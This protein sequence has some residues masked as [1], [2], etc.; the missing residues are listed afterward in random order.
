MDIKFFNVGQGDSILLEWQDDNL[1]KIGV[2]DCHKHKSGNPIKNYLNTKENF[3][4]EFII[5]SHPHRDH[6]SGI[7]ELLDFIESKDY[8]I[9]FFLHTVSV[10]PMYLNWAEI[11]E[12]DSI[13]LEL[14]FDKIIRFN[15]EKEII[16][17]I[18][19]GVENWSIDLNEKYAIKLLA[20]SDL[21]TRTFTSKINYYK[22]EN[23]NEC[24]AA[25]NLLS[26]V[27]KITNRQ[28][29]KVALLTSDAEIL[30]FE[31]LNKTNLIQTELDYFQV[32]HHGS[33]NNHLP[34]FWDSLKFK[35]N[36]K[37]IISAGKNKKYNH[38]DYEVVEYF[39]LRKICLESTNY[40]NGFKNYFDKL[41]QP[42]IK[43]ANSLD[44]ISEELEE[45]EVIEYL[46]Y[47]L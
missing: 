28:N 17:S 32:P 41:K 24:S 19:I 38:P 20:P 14:L 34:D 29:S 1:T 36:T 30:T 35:G 46:E 9:N 43:I 5:L 4:L 27:I 13:K 8:K 11:N 22:E 45:N 12:D 39:D 2:I 7:E 16:K 15:S 47:S 31:R 21:E 37:G 42:A 25:A 40:V 33:K 26:S 44:D 10:H 3:E 6:Y 23:Q 18:Q